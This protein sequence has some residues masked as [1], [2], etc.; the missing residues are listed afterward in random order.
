[1]AEEFDELLSTIHTLRAP[2]GCPWDRKQTLVDAAR[3]LL[4]EAGEAFQFLLHHRFRRGW[5][6]G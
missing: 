6:H 5:C 2:G 1:M 3:Y 4:D